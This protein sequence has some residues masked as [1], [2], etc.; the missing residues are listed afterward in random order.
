[1][2][3]GQIKGIGRQ[4]LRQAREQSSAIR[5]LESGLAKNKKRGRLHRYITSIHKEGSPFMVSITAGTNKF[6]SV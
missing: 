6:K 4:K 1:V 5:H 2:N 3:K